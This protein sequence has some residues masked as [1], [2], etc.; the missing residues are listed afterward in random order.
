MPDNEE[1]NVNLAGANASEQNFDREKH[2]ERLAQLEQFSRTSKEKNGR[3]NTELNYVVVKDGAQGQGKGAGTAAFRELVKGHL[4]AGRTGYIKLEAS[5]R[6]G[7]RDNSPQL[8]YL[9]MGMV[10]CYS[11]HEIDDYIPYSKKHLQTKYIPELIKIFKESLNSKDKTI[12]LN[13]MRER[14]FMMSVEGVNKWR[15]TIDREKEFTAFKDLS[16]L[17]FTPQQRAEFDQ[18]LAARARGDTDVGEIPEL[19]S[20]ATTTVYDE[21]EKQRDKRLEIE[22]LYKTFTNDVSRENFLAVAAL[23]D[24][25]ENISPRLEQ[26]NRFS[27]GSVQGSFKSLIFEAI[28][29][30]D[31]EV[32]N[33]LNKTGINFGKMIQ[34]NDARQFI[35]DKNV[36]CLVKLHDWKFDGDNLKTG[37]HQG[38][39]LSHVIGTQDETFVCAYLNTYKENNSP[40]DF[41]NLLKS[42][43]ASGG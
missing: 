8:F 7:A 31:T 2:K 30:N 18:I 12:N 13:R 10:P 24:E 37:D 33:A 23:Y 41:K 32:L 4:A 16:H 21:E 5:T 29:K 27:I 19:A 20:G 6:V 9:F 3:V 42:H 14:Y 38:S 22:G 35:A 43:I 34:E 17:P 1:K 11:E 36:A 28:A 15:S 39:I 25:Y 40:E 26:V